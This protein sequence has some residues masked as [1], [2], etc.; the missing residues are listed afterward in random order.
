MDKIKIIQVINNFLHNAIKFSHPFGK[1][2]IKAEDDG[3]YITT[4]VIDEGVGIPEFQ[5]DKL[6][7]IFSK[8]STAPTGGEKSNGLGLYISRKIIDAHG[9]IIGFE[10]NLLKGS[11]FYFKL[12]KNL[13]V[14]DV[15]RME[16]DISTVYPSSA[17]ERKIY[18]KY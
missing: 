4:K 2:I 17:I 3:D 14:E 8:T 18:T 9:G 13:S 15:L 7:K 5:K 11:I 6:F 12:R 16:H 1:I 10:Q